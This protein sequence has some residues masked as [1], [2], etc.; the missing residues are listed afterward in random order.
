MTM[1]ALKNNTEVSDS[2]PCTVVSTA[3]PP[4]QCSLEDSSMLVRGVGAH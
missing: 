2:V 3:H 4:D 1:S